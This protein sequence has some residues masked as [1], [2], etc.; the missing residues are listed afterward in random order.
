MPMSSAPEQSGPERFRFVFDGAGLSAAEAAPLLALASELAA[1]GHACELL[2]SA[3]ELTNLARARGLRACTLDEPARTTA[4]VGSGLLRAPFPALRAMAD[5]FLRDGEHIARSTVV[6][7]LDRGA[8]SNLLCE[9][10]GLRAVRLHTAPRSVRSLREPAPQSSSRLRLPALYAANDRYPQVLAHVNRERDRLDLAPVERASYAEPYLKHQVALFPRWYAEPVADASELS[11]AGFPA[12]EAA[13]ALPELVEHAEWPGGEPVVFDL[14]AGML[15]DAATQALLERCL[16]GLGLP[17]VVARQDGPARRLGGNLFAVSEAELHAML[18]HA[19][20]VVH[21]G[22]IAAVAR[23]LSAGVPQLIVPRGAEQLDNA[24]RVE[25]FGV[26]KQLA[27]GALSSESL[28]QAARALLALPGLRARLDELCARVAS[29]RVFVD[30]AD[31]IEARLCAPPE[32]AAVPAPRRVRRP[33]PLLAR[34]RTLAMSW[35]L[36]QAH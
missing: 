11:F 28:A 24:D 18:P 17:G 9:R 20:L 5:F 25:L 33:S 31:S 21:G 22:D 36:L 29:E 13:A 19:A 4:S 26:G 6:V 15:D 32:P 23:A 7:N 2:T 14:P 8:A 16:E 27:R 34:G 3:R 10:Q 12:Y 35:H 30:A 1:R